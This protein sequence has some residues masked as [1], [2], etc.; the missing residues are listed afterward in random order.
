M[1]APIQMASEWLNG[2]YAKPILIM[3]YV[4]SMRLPD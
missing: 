3:T 2:N 1:E 4:V